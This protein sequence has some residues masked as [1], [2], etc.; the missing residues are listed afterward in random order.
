[1]P[2]EQLAR[3]PQRAHR[4]RRSVTAGGVR[5]DREL[6]RWQHVE[7]VRLAVIL[8]DVGT[9]NR[10]SHNLGAGSVDG[11][12]SFCEVPVLAGTD[13]QARAVNPAGDRQAVWGRWHVSF[14]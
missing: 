12:T 11:G 10:D 2:F 13:E 9:A 8:A 6:R 1:M 4:V 7:Q 3:Q 5:Q 14:A